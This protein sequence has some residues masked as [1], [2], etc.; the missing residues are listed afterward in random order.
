MIFIHFQRDYIKLSDGDTFLLRAARESHKFH[1]TLNENEKDPDRTAEALYLLKRGVK[2]IDALDKVRGFS[3]M[4]Y[5]CLY[6]NFVLVENLLKYGA[7]VNVRSYFE[8]FT[9][10]YLASYY[11]YENIVKILLKQPGIE[12]DAQNTMGWT[13]LHAAARHRAQRYESILRLLLES[14]ANRNIVDK[15]GLTPMNWSDGKRFEIL[16]SAPIS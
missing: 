12:V 16:D 13:A 2:D 9:P 3:A 7:D 4:H 10:L 1:H 14:H 11:G 8:E 15:Y 6:G 5:A